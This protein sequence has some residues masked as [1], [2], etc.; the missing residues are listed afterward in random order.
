MERK[1]FAMIGVCNLGGTRVKTQDSE[2]LIKKRINT[3][4]CLQHL[5][6]RFFFKRKNIVKTDETVVV[7]LIKKLLSHKDSW[8]KKRNNLHFF[9]TGIVHV[10][11]FLFLS[12]YSDSERR[13]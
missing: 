6:L 2:S 7:T 1:V 5:P 13:S 4:K 9:H 10:C 12:R 8:V 3:L 11:F